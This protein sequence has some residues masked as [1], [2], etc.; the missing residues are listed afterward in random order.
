MTENQD[1]DRVVGPMLADA[2]TADA[3]VPD[4]LMARIAADAARVQDEWKQAAWRAAPAVRVPFW[5]QFPSV[6]GGTPAVGGLVAACAAGVWLGV[7]PPQGLDPLDFM[8][9]SSA[10]STLTVYSELQDT[11]Y[12]ED[13]L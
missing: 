12:S 3:Q 5:R 7:A 2:R 13:G 10:G 8:T 11:I 1:F 6:L 4:G 9:S